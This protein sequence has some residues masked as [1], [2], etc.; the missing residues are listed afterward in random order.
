M[1]NTILLLFLCIIL[2]CTKTILATGSP[3]QYL[4]TNQSMRNRTAVPFFVTEPYLQDI[5][6][7]SVT[8]GW[9]TAISS[10]SEIIY[11]NN[12]N[13]DGGLIVINSD[14]T[15]F[16]KIKIAGLNKS[17]TYYYQLRTNNI[18]YS[19]VYNFTTAPQTGT[20]IEY[21]IRWKKLYNLLLKKY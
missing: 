12:K 3:R 15:T 17:I 18:P 16:H 4:R 6:H 10:K 13:M 20:N 14:S 9:N 5:S 11:N 19:N 21:K 1:N 7:N 2:N 8:I